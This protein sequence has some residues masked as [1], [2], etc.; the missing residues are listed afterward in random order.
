MPCIVFVK[1]TIEEDALLVNCEDIIDAMYRLILL[2]DMNYIPV[3]LN[4][5]DIELGFN[6]NNDKA[7]FV[8]LLDN[9]VVD[10]K[11]DTLKTINQ[12]FCEYA[13]TLN[14]P[15]WSMF[16]TPALGYFKLDEAERELEET[17][18]RVESI[19]DPVESKNV[20]I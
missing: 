11:R 6:A 9:A 19:Y 8:S 18:R 12:N 1:K 10:Y 20:C 16:D 4:C 15:D 3:S 17:L 5:P 7:F 14:R 13:K 2:K